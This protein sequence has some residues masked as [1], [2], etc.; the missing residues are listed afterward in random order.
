MTA[1]GVDAYRIERICFYVTTRSAGDMDLAA[2]L[3]HSMNDRSQHRFRSR[4]E[5][6]C[7]YR[8]LLQGGY[9]KR[10]FRE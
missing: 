3:Y 1:Q 2:I 6:A 5:T 9:L 7:Y 4:D 10:R 8:C